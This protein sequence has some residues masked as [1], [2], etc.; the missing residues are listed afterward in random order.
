MLLDDLIKYC[1]ADALPMHMPGHKRNTDKFPWLARLGGDID[2][3]EIDGFDN[4]NDPQTVFAGLEARMARMWGADESVCLVGGSTQGAFAA[5]CSSLLHGGS[6]LLCRN[7]HKSLYHAAET[8]RADVHYIMPDT[9]GD[10]IIGSVTPQAA[11]D[12]LRAHPDAAVVAVTSPTYEGVISDIAKIADVCHRYGA[13]LFVDE[14]HGAHLGFGGFP[15]S[16]VTCGADIVVQSLHKT[17]PSLT[18]TAALHIRC[19]FADANEVRRC[20][21]MFGTSSP[22]YILSASID[23][24]VSYLEREGDRAADEWLSA[25]GSFRARTA[26]MR[27]LKIYG[28]G[29]TFALDPSKIVVTTSRADTDGGGLVRLAREKYNIEPEAEIGDNV[30]FMTGM[31][32]TESSLQRLADALCDIDRTCAAA[33]KAP[34]RAPALPIKSIN[35]WEAVRRRSETVPV[36]ECAGRTAAEYVWAY[37]PGIPL[38]VPGE[39][40]NEDIAVALS[41]DARLYSTRRSARGEICVLSE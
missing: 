13:L 3:T 38:I 37:P 30:I 2:I 10:G 15:A 36:S 12:A 39:I 26:G 34:A 14:A 41:S 1:G 6:L 33:D 11:E 18:Q 28:G 27:H 21:A 17:L 5:I 31:G 4:L 24:C 23:A 9:D 25:L 16:A 35:A 19:G 22:S 20:A 40:I 7:A 29:D 8:A 32:D